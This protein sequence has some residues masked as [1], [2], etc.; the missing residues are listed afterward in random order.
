LAASTTGGIWNSSSGKA[1]VT[2]GVVTGVAA[3]NDII[4]YTVSNAWCQ[5]TVTHVI[6]VETFP[7]AK[8]ISG[9]E[10]MCLGETTTLTDSAV[11]GVWMSGSP[12]ASVFAITP[13][14]PARCIVTALAAG[15]ASISYSVTNSCGTARTTHPVAIYPLPDEP[16]ISERLGL[17][18][19]P[20]LYESYQWTQNGEYIP[21]ANEDTFYVKAPSLYAVIVSNVYGCKTSSNPLSY[22]GCDPDDMLVYPNPTTATVRILWCQ[23]VNARIMSIDGRV[24][25]RYTNV[26]E[27]SLEG[28]PSAI[29]MVD[30]FNEEDK[31]IKTVRITRATGQ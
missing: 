1:T 10:Q 30:I 16:I 27:V 13:V 15:A 8:T 9:L 28:L 7:D 12:L 23:K 31:P 22:A 14:S 29:Y 2:A 21:G 25:R 5:S 11:G 17:M 24:L 20:A 19:V 26:T 6:T 4:R 18:S 3:G